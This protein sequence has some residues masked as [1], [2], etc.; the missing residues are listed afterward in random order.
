MPADVL[1]ALDTFAAPLAQLREAGTRAGERVG[2][3]SVQAARVTPLARLAG[4]LERCA[5]PAEPFPRLLSELT[6]DF[7]ASLPAEIVNGEPHRYRRTDE[8]H[9]LL[10][11]VG[12]DLRDL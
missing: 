11:S 4:A 3:R 5:S 6:P 8:G 9:F 12:P 10:Y 1:T 7:L 2:N